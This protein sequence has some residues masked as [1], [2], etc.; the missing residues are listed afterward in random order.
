M[1]TPAANRT[2]SLRRDVL[3]ELNPYELRDVVVAGATVGDVGCETIAPTCVVCRTL[4]M[5]SL[6]C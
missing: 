2:L 3:T 4:T 6:C 1:L 5:C